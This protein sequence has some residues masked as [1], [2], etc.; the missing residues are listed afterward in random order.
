MPRAIHSLCPSCGKPLRVPAELVNQAVRCRHC[1][2]VIRAQKKKKT[3]A[4]PSSAGAPDR[5]GDRLETSDA[6]TELAATEDGSQTVPLA[7]ADPIFRTR[8][9]LRRSRRNKWIALFLIGA[10][11]LAAAAGF[12]Y[13][14][15]LRLLAAEWQQFAEDRESDPDGAPPKDPKSETHVSAVQPFPRRALAICINNYLYANPVSYGE[16]GHN[17]HSLME[18]LSD[19]FRIAP[20]QVFELSDAVPAATPDTARAPSAK[21]AVKPKNGLALPKA[22]PPLKSIIEQTIT[23]FLETSRAQ[24]R[25]L[26]VFCGHALVVENEAYLV[27]LEGELT[28][29]ATLI[30]FTWVYDQMR[31]CPARQKVLIVDTCR[32][33]PTR[34]LERPGSGPMP[35]RLAEILTEPPEGVQVWSSCT[36]GQYGHE[37]D[38]TSVFLEKLQESLTQAVS[39]KTQE[40]RD[41]F[42]LELVTKAVSQATSSQVKAELKV[43]QTP[44]LKGNE[45]AEGTPPDPGERE[46]EKIEVPTPSAEQGATATRSDIEGILREIEIPPIKLIR[47]QTAPLLIGALIPFPARTMEPYKADKVSISEVEAAAEKYPLRVSILRVVKQLNDEFSPEK[48]AVSFR[49]SFSGGKSDQIKAEILKEQTKPARVLLD[50]Q[51]SLDQLRNAGGKRDQEKSKRW[52][53]HYDYVLAQLLARIAYVSE[54][55][56]MLGKIRKDELPELTPN[57]HSGYRLCSQEKLQS[58]KEVRDLAVESRKILMKLAE[59]HRGTPWEI[60]AKRAQL[61]FLGLRW[62]PTR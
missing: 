43:E 45:A 46:P 21:K 3:S 61:T 38:G 36:T 8:E 20:S 14:E 26:I 24:D 1:G 33:D 16:P 41:S 17:V 56:L 55:N 53:A 6:L 5:A 54:Y 50:L 51:E 57:V 37:L 18:R 27:P 4:Q 48:A 10:T 59:D 19:A 60:L 31:K 39:K 25:I 32:L 13:R 58:S 35:A 29:K 12:L 28:N 23:R 11:A 40:A 9:Y 2:K 34:G 30:P 42:P 52:Q 7:D 15:R 47:E 49:E 44:R 22:R 62:E